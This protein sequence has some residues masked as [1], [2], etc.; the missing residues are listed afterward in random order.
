MASEAFVDSY[1]SV[2]GMILCVTARVQLPR[3]DTFLLLHLSPAESYTALP[4]HHCLEIWA[5]LKY[6]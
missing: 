6:K 1:T 3:N 5:D 2:K 4:T